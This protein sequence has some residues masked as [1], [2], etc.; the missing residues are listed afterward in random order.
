MRM[1]III[2]TIIIRNKCAGS[3]AESLCFGRIRRGLF[4]ELNRQF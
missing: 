4:A 2:I 1:T 3:R